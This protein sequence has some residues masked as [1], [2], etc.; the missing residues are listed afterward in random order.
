MSGK[1]I[2]FRTKPRN[3][4]RS[5]NGRIGADLR[6]KKT[7]LFCHQLLLIEP[8]DGVGRIF[9]DRGQ[10]GISKAEAAGRRLVEMMGQGPEGI[11]IPF[12][13]QKVLL[14]IG[15]QLLCKPGLSLPF[16]LPEKIADSIFP[17]MT[18]GG[19]A[20][21]MGQTSRCNAGWQLVFVKFPE[22]FAKRMI[23][24]PQHIPNRLAKRTP[25]RRHFQTM[26]QAIV[27]KYRP[28]QRK[29]LGFVLQPA[30]G[31]GK[32]NAVVI[33]QKRSPEMRVDRPLHHTFTRT[34]LR[35]TLTG[36]PRNSF[37]R[38]APRSHRAIQLL[39]VHFFHVALSFFRPGSTF[40][41][42]ETNN[43]V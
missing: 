35:Y 18:K 39:P 22:P 13:A 37:T 10:R 34:R 28:G 17:G 6:V 29:D 8:T 26:R 4:Q 36:L 11:R 21:I 41:R 25:H 5:G 24:I 31:G 14:L 23:F 40:F 43:I 2:P 7:G 33:P 12:K 9:D 15:R 38:P 3:T 20:D 19:I 30:E 1:N 27:D 16:Q 42:P 32:N